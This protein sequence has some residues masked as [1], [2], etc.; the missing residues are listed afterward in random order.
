MISH[1]PE[2]L[3]RAVLC[4]IGHNRLLSFLGQ[5]LTE[6]ESITETWGMLHGNVGVAI[7][8]S[9]CLSFM[10]AKRASYS[11]VLEPAIPSHETSCKHLQT[12]VTQ[13]N[14]RS[15]N[16]SK[17]HN[18][19]PLHTH[20]PT[21]PYSKC[22][23]TLHRKAHAHCTHS[24]VHAC[25]YTST[26]GAPLAKFCQIGTNPSAKHPQLQLP[27]PGNPELEDSL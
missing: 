9:Q 16:I 10:T 11:I 21:C 8:S 23:R 1:I 17:P 13:S 18:L 2:S 7:L 26:Q 22:P 24:R 20:A 4:K 25:T 6:K 5:N 14:K 15:R 12:M 3:A 27:G 19:R